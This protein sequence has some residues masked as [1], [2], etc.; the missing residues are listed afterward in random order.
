MT[1]TD[2]LGVAQACIHIYG[3]VFLLGGA[4]I[5][6]FG[7][8]ALLG[9][10]VSYDVSGTDL[11]KAFIAFMLGLILAVYGIFLLVVDKKID[12]FKDNGTIIVKP[13]VP[14]PTPSV[15]ATPVPAE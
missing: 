10:A 1:I 9:N 3:L 7:A 11:T 5:S 12:V 4:L 2:P 6:L 13:Y 15:E 14:E 8:G